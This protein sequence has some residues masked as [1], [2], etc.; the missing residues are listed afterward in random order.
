[1]AFFLHKEMG[2]NF[3]EI[4]RLT[5]VEVHALIDQFNKNNKEQE[6]KHKAAMRKSKM[7]RR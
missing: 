4:P 1:M 3:F 5:T 7:R 2:Y 6:R